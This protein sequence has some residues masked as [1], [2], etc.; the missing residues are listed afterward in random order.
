MK[1]EFLG[2]SSRVCVEQHDGALLED[3][4]LV[5]VLE[6]EFGDECDEIAP[7]REALAWWRGD[8]GA[9]RHLILELSRVEYVDSY[10]MSELLRP[11]R[12][13]R[14][15]GEAGELGEGGAGRGGGSVQLVV[16]GRG[17]LRRRLERNGYDALFRLHER[18]EEALVAIEQR[19]TAPA[20]P[21]VAAPPATLP[22]TP[23]TPEP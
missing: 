17:S 7:L 6:G 15:R 20:P 21:L 1:N 8:Q 13:T 11:L 2:T 5:L 23:V 10:F 18:L 16:P 14:L 3:D 19:S 9:R 12:A 4:A 22:A